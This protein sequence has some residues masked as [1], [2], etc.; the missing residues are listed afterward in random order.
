VRILYHHRTLADGA[1]GVH[2]SAMVRAFED[3]GHD[4][5][6]I[7]VAAGGG[8]TWRQRAAERLRARLPRVAFEVILA[9]L[10]IPEYLQARQEFRTFKPDLIYKRHARYDVGLLAAA[11]RCS[12]PS[13]LEVNCLFTTPRY[14]Q[15]EPL[16]ISWGARALERQALQ[17]ATVVVTVSSPLTQDAKTLATRARVLTIP[18]GA[19]PVRFD[20]Q[21]A[22][23][24]RIRAKYGLE[25]RLV[26][27]WAGIIR[28][29]HGLELL[30]ES[31]RQTDA[32][33]LLV[34][35]DGEAR[36]A[37][38]RKA[39][40][41]G[42]LDRLVITGRVPHAEMA[43][44]LAALDIAVVA[45]EQTGVASPMKLLEYM[46]M[47]R[48]VVAPRADNIRD[49]V[50]DGRNGLLFRP[51]DANDLAAVLLRLA[52]DPALRRSLGESARTTVVDERNWQA[53][54][55]TVLEA[56]R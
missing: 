9:A 16:A 4:V 3:L 39:A 36:P 15:F 32:A 51:G 54:A 7:G 27:G 30:L 25:G 2:I 17:L 28:E 49:L 23:G 14:A 5:R 26:I 53:I 24:D 31:L 55:R 20:P 11:R 40:T 34:I 33:H 42:V 50:D 45:D 8:S 46:A 12:I 43:D 41:M 18:N 35:G 19:D 29:W 52:D 22:S 47:A 48:A 13:V 44:Y 10:N 21:R 37:I 38:E 6:V 1:E 56:S